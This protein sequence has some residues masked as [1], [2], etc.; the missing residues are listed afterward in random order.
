MSNRVQRS[1]TYV[2][3]FGSSVDGNN[4]SRVC[5]VDGA[6]IP[7]NQ[8]T[9]VVNSI[10]QCQVDGLANGQHTLVVTVPTANANGYWFDSLLY[11]PSASVS[12]AN[13]ALEVEWNDPSMS[14]G[15]GWTQ[16][17]PGM[18]ATTNGASMTVQF[19]G[20]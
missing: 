12:R 2:G 20:A 13:A 10:M 19:T 18:I 4:P 5:T 3:V 16:S 15:S 1:G 7:N 14:Y 11:I 8:I 17:S 6:T 9:S